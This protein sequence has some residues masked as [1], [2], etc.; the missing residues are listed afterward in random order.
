[1]VR[2]IPV[3]RVNTK[4]E[5][6][7]VA[8][9]LAIHKVVMLVQTADRRIFARLVNMQMEMR[10][11]EVVIPIHKLATIVKSVNINLQTLQQQMLVRIA[12]VANLL[13]VD[14]QPPVQYVEKD[15]SKI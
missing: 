4:P 8:V 9:P 7:A 1:M 14:P 13:T 6:R 5:Q 3:D 2:R 12:V 11:L 15:G 10:V